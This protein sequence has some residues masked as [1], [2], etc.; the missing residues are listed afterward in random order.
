MP[1]QG[2]SASAPC[3]PAGFPDGLFLPLLDG[4]KGNGRNAL[5]SL[6]FSCGLRLNNRAAGNW[7]IYSRCPS[8]DIRLPAL[9]NPKEGNG[10]TGSAHN[11]LQPDSAW[12]FSVA[13]FETCGHCRSLALVFG[14]L[15]RSGIADAARYIA[16][17]LPAASG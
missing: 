2:G 1:R 8:R 4:A 14:I 15:T 17:A 12:N 6:A 13:D 5:I 7:L 11:R 9:E 10:H 3:P 16:M